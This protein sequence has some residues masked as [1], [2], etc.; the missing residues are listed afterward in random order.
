MLVKH[1]L[2]LFNFQTFILINQGT[3]DG[4]VLS[5]PSHEQENVLFIP[6]DLVWSL[7]QGANDLFLQSRLESGTWLDPPKLL[8]CLHFPPVRHAKQHLKCS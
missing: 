4:V 5:K 6:N 3:H 8:N 7:V 1:G 2:H